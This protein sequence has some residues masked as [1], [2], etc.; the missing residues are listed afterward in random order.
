METVTSDAPPAAPKQEAERRH[1]T[2][3]FCDLAGS[4]ALSEQLDPEDLKDVIGVFQE[5]CAREIKTYGGYIARYMG[6]GILVYFGYP[7]AHEDD[8]ERSVRAGL[9]IVTGVTGLEPRPGL[10]LQV[11]VGIATGSVVAGDIIGEGASEEHAVLGVTPN[12]AARLQSLAP[13][14]GLVISDATQR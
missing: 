10:E 14:N 3:M 8:P 13:P 12:L 2:V 1:L 7:T 6:D 5:L 4:T 9:N 11:R